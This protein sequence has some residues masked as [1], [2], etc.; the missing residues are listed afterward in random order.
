MKIILKFVVCVTGFLISDCL[1]WSQTQPIN[2]TGTSKKGI[3]FNVLDYG[4]NSNGIDDASTGINAAIQAAKDSGGGIVFI[5][6]GNY[7]CGPIELVSDLEL[8]I[9]AGATL[10]FPAQN[11][12]FTQGRNQG[13]ECLAPVPLIGGHNLENV[14]IK[15]GGKITTSN[16]EWMKLKPR[17]GGSAAGP[18][19]ANLLSSLEEKTPATEDEYRKAATELRPPFIQ[20]MN[21]KNVHIEDIHIVGSP[22]WTV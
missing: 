5:P 6:S 11:L 12:P 10:Y 17:Y 2:S 15:G 20:V 8:Y 7:T 9:E 13:I 19:W 3:F 16:S 4:A 1:S 18:D 22:M 21:C 14:T